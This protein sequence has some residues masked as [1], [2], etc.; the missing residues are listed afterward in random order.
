MFLAQILAKTAAITMFFNQKNLFFKEIS[1]Q[2][3]FDFTFRVKA[4]WNLS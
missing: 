1:T 2:S 4:V 3:L